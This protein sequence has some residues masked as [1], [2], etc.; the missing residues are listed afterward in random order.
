[1]KKVSIII[2]AYNVGSF[3]ERCLNSI[4]KQTYRNFEV[5]IVNDGSKDNTEEVATRFCYTHENFTYI[6]KENGG[7]SSARNLGL[8]YATG[9]YVLFIDSDDWI[10]ETFVENLVKNIKD[11]DSFCQISEFKKVGS[12]SVKD[13]DINYEFAKLF[14]I[15]SVWSKLFNKKVIDDINLRFSNVTMGED[16]EFCAK[17]Y[18]QNSSISMATG[19]IYYY[20]SN[21]SSLTHTFNAHMYSVMDAIENIEEFARKTNKFDLHYSLLEYINIFHILI[22]LIKSASKMD[23]FSTNEIIRLL[24]Y[25][26]RKYPNWENNKNIAYCT[27]AEKKYLINLK[28]RN[29]NEILNYFKQLTESK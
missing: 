1:M 12:D 18:I 2:P 27:D 13:Y 22:C 9:D 4:D 25:V 19:S 3:I 7:V 5:L 21:E 23:N 16:L 17:A 10:N 14:R 24:E 29:I 26:E 6:K 8:D 28:N 11:E 20:F 15:A